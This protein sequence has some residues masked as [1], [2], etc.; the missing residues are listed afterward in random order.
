MVSEGISGGRA[1]RCYVSLTHGKMRHPLAAPDPD[2][3]CRSSR[4]C[5]RPWDP[6]R[7]GA[8][9]RAGPQRSDAFLWQPGLLNG[10]ARLGRAGRD[11]RLSARASRRGRL[12]GNAQDSYRAAPGRRGGDSRR[13]RAGA[14]A[15]GGQGVADAPG[16]GPIEKD[17]CGTTSRSSSPSTEH[18]SSGG[19]P[20][21]VWAV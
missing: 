7:D 3:G 4:G 16:V 5:T 13:T 17:R 15:R 11:P 12:F 1:A 20:R 8:K 14:G 2:L 9:K 18:R 21:Q 10:L 6:G 19:T